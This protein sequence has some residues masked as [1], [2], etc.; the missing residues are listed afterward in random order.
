MDAMSNNSS[1]DDANEVYVSSGEDDQK[2]DAAGD[3][4]LECIGEL[5]NWMLLNTRSGYPVS[6]NKVAEYFS[7]KKRGRGFSLHD[8]IKKTESSLS[9]VFGFQIEITASRPSTVEVSGTLN[10]ANASRKKRKTHG[11]KFLNLIYQPEAEVDEK[12]QKLVNDI[13]NKK[14]DKYSK[15]RR[16]ER[17]FL[18]LI[19]IGIFLGGGHIDEEELKTMI[20][21]YCKVSWN[22]PKHPVLGDIPALLIRLTK[23]KML[24]KQ[25]APGTTS[26]EGG[27]FLW[28][29]GT[30]AN[31]LYPKS[32]LYKAYKEMLGDDVSAGD[33]TYKRYVDAEKKTQQLNE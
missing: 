2:M 27:S 15:R 24:F 13:I 29:A 28:H 21:N 10:I 4:E 23:Q 12:E 22:D 18:V 30:R 14:T 6:R 11:S 16:A 25:K 9:D 20:Q 7:A 32:F 1:G 31:L 19:L 8:L 33:A 5:A 26:G 3:N 17:A